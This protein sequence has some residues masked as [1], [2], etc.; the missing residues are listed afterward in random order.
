VRGRRLKL[1]TRIFRP[2]GLRVRDYA[3]RAVVGTR[4][5]LA[6]EFYMRMIAGGYDPALIDVLADHRIIYVAVP[7][8]ASS[9]IKILLSAFLGRQVSSPEKANKRRLSGLK[10]PHHVGLSVFYRLAMDSNTLRFSFVRN[11]Y[12]RLV[13]CWAD[14]FQNKPLIAGDSFVEQYLAARTQVDPSLPAGADR[15]LSFADFARFVTEPGMQRLNAH[16]WRQV[17]LVDGPA[18]TL[19]FIGRV[20]SF[21]R[22]FA[23]VFDHVGAGEELRSRSRQPINASS[24]RPWKDYYTTEI[25]AAVYRAYEHDFD[26]FGYPRSMPG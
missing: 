23:H 12:A 20:E 16:W 18:I 6:Y 22:D 15:T 26:R 24:H 11:P 19:E 5:P 1:V 13:S 14:K 25:A 8:A 4:D 2:Y 3:R 7:K 9:R 17:E 21:D 10:A